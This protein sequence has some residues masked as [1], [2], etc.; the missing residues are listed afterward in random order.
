MGKYPTWKGGSCT[1]CSV[2]VLTSPTLVAPIDD[3]HKISRWVCRQ[4]PRLVPGKH[5]Q[6]I[7]ELLDELYE[8]HAIAFSTTRDVM[9][10]GIPNQAAALLENPSLSEGHRRALEI[11]T[12]FHD[13]QYSRA[14]EPDNMAQVENQTRDLMQHLA[15][16]L[17]EHRGN[18]EAWIFGNQPTIL[19]AHAAVL[20]ARMMDLE[21]LDLIPDRVRVYANSVKETAEW[22]QLTQG[23]PTFSNASLGPATNR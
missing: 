18:S 13:S 14:L 16:L 2:P 21:R 6:A 23:Q 19:D 11:K 15:L 4:Q 17:E 12:M 20:V 7:G 3:S 5:R 10:N 22:E 1:E 8:I 9:R